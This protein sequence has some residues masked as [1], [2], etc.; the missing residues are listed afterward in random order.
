MPLITEINERVALAF[1]C[2]V[3]VS[4][5]IPMAIITRRREKSINSGIAFLT[6]GVYYLFLLGSEALS[7]QGHL[8]PTIGMW[9]PNV[10]FLIIGAILTFKVCVY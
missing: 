1:S 6:V 9:I 8:D 7:L 2:F 4:L 10:I 5:G 3:F